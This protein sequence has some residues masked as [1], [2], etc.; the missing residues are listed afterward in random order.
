MI[1]D[2]ND[3]Q[4]NDIS[5]EAIIALAHFYH[6]TTEEVKNR[7]KKVRGYIYISVDDVYEFLYHQS[8]VWQSHFLLEFLFEIGFTVKQ[9]LFQFDIVKQKVLFYDHPKFY[10][11]YIVE[12]SNAQKLVLNID[13]V[14]DRKIMNLY[15]EKMYDYNEVMS[16]YRDDINKVDKFSKKDIWIYNKFMVRFYKKIVKKYP[17][18][19]FCQLLDMEY[20]KKQYWKDENLV[21][22]IDPN[23]IIDKIINEFHEKIEKC[24]TTQNINIKQYLDY[25]PPKESIKQINDQ[26]VETL[27]NYQIQRFLINPYI[28]PFKDYIINELKSHSQLFI[29]NLFLN[30][31]ANGF[32]DIDS[33]LDKVYFFVK[34]MKVNN[35]SITAL[36]EFLHAIEVSEYY[37]SQNIK[38]I[39]CGLS[40]D[41]KNV[42][43]R[44][45]H[46]DLLN[47]IIHQL[48]TE[49]LYQYLLDN[50]INLFKNFQYLNRIQTTYYQEYFILLND[51][52][53]KYKGYLHE[54][55]FHDIEKMEKLFQEIPFTEYYKINNVLNECYLENHLD[56]QKMKEKRKKYYLKRIKNFIEK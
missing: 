24:K 45:S 12:S 41:Q 37:D 20:T 17:N 29:N 28:N 16:C 40:L 44:I 34:A 32:C 55:K 51:F 13:Q 1:D 39:K 36:H 6:A 21:S 18:E 10:E 31:E 53:Q 48:S 56:F 38:R 2:K 8:K 22:K 14:D 52:Y 47:E 42:K 35:P 25:I 46:Y 7:I 50:K 11:R 15:Q 33:Y 9:E 4:L 26:L 49:E 27:D 5:D 54:A 30:S 3:L 43:T 23:S 19:S